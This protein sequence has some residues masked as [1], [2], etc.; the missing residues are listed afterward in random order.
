M[1]KALAAH[2]EVLSSAIEGHGGWLFKH[3]GPR[4]HLA[5]LELAEATCMPSVEMTAVRRR[6]ERGGRERSS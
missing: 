6:S 3:T 4:R 2:D 5:R 1:R